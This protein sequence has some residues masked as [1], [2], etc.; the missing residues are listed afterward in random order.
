MGG[1]QRLAAW[2]DSKAIDRRQFSMEGRGQFSNA[3]Y[4]A[5]AIR[6]RSQPKG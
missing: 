5:D 3:H 6:G 4:I 1:S 2:L